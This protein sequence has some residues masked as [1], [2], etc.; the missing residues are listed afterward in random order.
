MLEIRA[1]VD[2]GRQ[3]HDLRTVHLLR[4]DVAQRLQKLDAVAVDGP[5]CDPLH[6]VGAGALHGVAIFDHVGDAGGRP[7]LILEHTEDALLVAHNVDAA[8][9]HGGSEANGELP[10][11]RSVVRVA[12]YEAGRHDAVLQDLL[13]VVEVVQ[14]QIERAHPLH[15]AGLE[16][17]PFPRRDDTRHRI[18][19]QDSV[20]RIRLGVNCERDAEVEQVAF[21]LGGAATEIV[22]RKGR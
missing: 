18:E 11:L 9:V 7:C 4:C 22:D 12:E 19:G 8:D 6:Q 15:D 3:K 21:G 20:D 1:V 5:E 2:A 14:E 13:A 17:P 16:H 10:H